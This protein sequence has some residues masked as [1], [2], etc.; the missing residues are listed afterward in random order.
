M[1]GK[2]TL[3]KMDERL[4]EMWSLSINSVWDHEHTGYENLGQWL[5]LTELQCP[6]LEHSSNNFK[7]IH[8]EDTASTQCLE[9]HWELAIP[10]LPTQ[11]G[12]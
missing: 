9:G 10:G 12:L 7:F 5:D 4:K 1:S 11:E 8:D 2:K 6:Q 3:F